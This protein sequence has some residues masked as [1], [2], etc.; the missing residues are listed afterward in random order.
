MTRVPGG[1]AES[2]SLPPTT[3][4]G[5]TPANS[6]EGGM[7]AS[8]YLGMRWLYGQTDATSTS[9]SP[10]TR[11]L[12]KIAA[13]LAAL[14]RQIAARRQR[15]GLR[16]FGGGDDDGFDDDFIDGMSSE[17]RLA[18][19]SGGMGGD[20]GGSGGQSH[21]DEQGGSRSSGSVPKVEIKSQNIGPVPDPAPGVL[22]ARLTAEGRDTVDHRQLADDWL[23]DQLSQ[24]AKLVAD[25]NYR[26]DAA[27]LA[28]LLDLL[29]T[30]QQIGPFKPLGMAGWC[31]KLQAL[32]PANPVNSS[33]ATQAAAGAVSLSVAAGKRE[34][35]CLERFNALLPLKLLEFDKTLLPAKAGPAINTVKTQYNATLARH[36]KR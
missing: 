32:S 18:E 28:S 13:R 6:P 14:K 25:P 24:R 3:S 9:G 33:S 22:A 19:A 36:S 15:R 20:G 16:R 11:Q 26:P 8:E 17:H 1:P 5:S 31:E 29:S 30:K 27:Y 10:Q 35:T 23:A 2:P 4:D 7:R 12:A 21:H 34:L